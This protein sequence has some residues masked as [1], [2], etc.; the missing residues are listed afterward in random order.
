MT[1]P[2]S[3]DELILAEKIIPALKAIMAER[4]CDLHESMDEF[5]RRYDRLRA[6]RPGEFTLPPEKYGRN[7]YS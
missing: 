5:Q 6:E 7:V 4:G 3:I 1:D 2:A